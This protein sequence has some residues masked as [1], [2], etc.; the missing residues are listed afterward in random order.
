M[1]QA[2]Q[3]K[4]AEAAKPSP[5]YEVSDAKISLPIVGGIALV[6]L[7]LVAVLLVAGVFY[8]LVAYHDAKD[9]GLSPMAASRMPPQG[10][11]LLPDTPDQVEAQSVA[12]RALLTRYSWIDKENGFVRIPLDRAMRLVVQR[13]LPTRP[14]GGTQQ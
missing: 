5:G 2:Q 9:E 13:G 4:P 3:E 1:D 8:A 7:L 10:P 6:M 14:Q 11:R 12:E